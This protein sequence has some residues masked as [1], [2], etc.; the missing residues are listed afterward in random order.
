MDDLFGHDEPT[1]SA[2]EV[3]AEGA[4]LF[5]GLALPHDDELLRALD[6]VTAAAPFR[7]MVTPG[8]FTMSV[9]M[10]NCGAAGWVTD[11]SGYRYDRNDP[12]SG[13]PWPEMPASFLRLAIEAATEAGYPDFRPDACLIS[14]YE[15]GARLSL[16]QDK[17]E[18]DFAIRSFLFRSAYPRPSNSAA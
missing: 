12:E 4:M 10:T 18:R 13:K 16:H 15:P 14:R 1:L 11:R 6:D 3:I 7:H 2:H 9:A 5:R 17:N 8:G